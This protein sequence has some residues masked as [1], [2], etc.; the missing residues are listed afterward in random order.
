RARAYGEIL[1][2]ECAGAD[3]H[4]REFFAGD[5]LV[6]LERAVF[7]TLHDACFRC[8][9]YRVREPISGFYVGEGGGT[10]LAAQTERTNDDRCEF[11][12]RNAAVGAEGAVFIT[13]NDQL[14]GDRL[15][16]S[17]APVSCHI[18]E[19]LVEL[20]D[21]VDR[22]RRALQRSYTVSE[23]SRDERELARS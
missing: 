21:A 16:I 4:S 5:D 11:S 1:A 15:D 22:V 8:Y 20:Y 7:I 18:R 3:H 6:R 13:F 2:C 9:R 14:V 19:S 10:L 12:A 23:R 17:L